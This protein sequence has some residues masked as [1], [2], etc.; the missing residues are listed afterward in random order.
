MKEDPYS[1]QLNFDPSG[2]PFVDRD[3]YT[4]EKD[5]KCVVCAKED[6]YVKKMVVP[7]D[8]RRHFPPNFKDHLSHDILLLCVSCHRL[9]EL[10]DIRLKRKIADDYGIPLGNSKSIDDPV[11]KRVRSAAK[12]LM[13]AGEKLP[14]PRKNELTQIVKDFT[15]DEL[16]DDT[17]LRSLSEIGT[18]KDNECYLGPHGERVVQ[19]LIETDTVK[20]FV[21]M[22][23]E[24]FLKTMKP[25]H[26][27]KLWSVDHNLTKF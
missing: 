3:Y 25:K 7:R 26:L 8:Y 11:L 9:S 17:T 27:P 20:E 12:A 4:T 14:E 5:N 2:R 6:N 1:V 23:R 18:T 21:K 13:H 19:K 16:I 10:H 24:H 15:S 22:W